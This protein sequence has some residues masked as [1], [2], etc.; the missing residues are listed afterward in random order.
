MKLYPKNFT[1]LEPSPTIAIAIVTLSL[2][3][4]HPK[5]TTKF[6]SES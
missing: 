1:R 2:S 3:L 6:F 4:T 5:L